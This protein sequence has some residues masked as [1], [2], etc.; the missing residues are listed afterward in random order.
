MSSRQEVPLADLYM[1]A[2]AG[3]ARPGRAAVWV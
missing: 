2:G 1:R 3:P